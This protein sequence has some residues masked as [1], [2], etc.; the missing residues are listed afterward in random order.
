MS[1]NIGALAVGDGKGK[2]ERTRDALLAA[3]IRLFSEQGYDAT[4]TRQVE[5][6]AGVQRN[7]MTYHFGGK[8]DFWKACMVAL[9]GRMGALLEPVFDQSKDIAPR[10]RVRFLI[11]R[12]VRASAAVP[13]VARILFDE[14][15][16]SGWRLEWLVDNYIR[17][18][19]DTIAQV[20]KE[21]RQSNAIPD[22][23]L[24]NFYYFLAASGAMFSMS[25]EFKLLTGKDA[26]EDAMVDAQANA[27]ADLLTAHT[28]TTVKAADAAND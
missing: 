16:S 25:A 14:G 11:R 10:E 17:S 22:I 26:F 23:P 8:E 2:S 7:L 3:G 4:S 5:A 9:N 15:R 27:I 20:F 12:Y 6:L 19:F 24:I 18:F 1:A 13:E 21:G 28:H